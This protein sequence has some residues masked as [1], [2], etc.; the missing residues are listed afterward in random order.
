ME[1]RLVFTEDSID[2]YAE[3]SAELLYSISVQRHRLFRKKYTI[4][5]NAVELIPSF[6]SSRKWTIKQKNKKIGRIVFRPWILGRKVK[7]DLKYEIYI[8][9]S[10]N[11]KIY[12]REKKTL[13]TG[14]VIEAMK[15]S[16]FFR[17]VHGEYFDPTIS[18]LLTVLMVKKKRI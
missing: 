11:S 18:S 6:L 13:N 9:S 8:S 1:Y 12:F 7:L 16:N 10:V 14:I 3:A 2:L 17:I 5:T 4:S 15:S